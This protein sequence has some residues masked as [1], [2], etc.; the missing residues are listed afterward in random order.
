MREIITKEMPDSMMIAKVSLLLLVLVVDGGL[1][2]RLQI[3]MWQA[4][5]GGV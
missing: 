4:G 5:V 3:R 2:D 1:D